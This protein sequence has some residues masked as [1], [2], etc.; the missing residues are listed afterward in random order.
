MYAEASFSKGRLTLAM[1]L[2]VHCAIQML[3]KMVER[4]KVLESHLLHGDQLITPL[5]F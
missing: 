3:Y 2:V 1:S 5:Y 4:N